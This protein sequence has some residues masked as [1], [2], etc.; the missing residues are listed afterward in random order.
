MKKSHRFNKFII[1]L[2]NFFWDLW[3][4]LSIIGIW[5]R[6][7]ENKLVSRTFKRF[8]ISYLP[9]DL[10][11]LKIAQFSDL[12][13]H[14]QVPQR[15]LEKIKRKIESFQPDIIVFTGDFLCFSLSRDLVRLEQFF[16]SLKAPYGCFAV[17]GNHDY[18]AFVSVNEQ[19]EYDVLPASTGSI[20]KVLKRLWTTKI[21][22]RRATDRARAVRPH[23][24]LE[25]TLGKTHFRLLKNESLLV[26]IKDTF[27]N[28]VGLEE[29]STGR[30]APA[31]A[32]QTVDPRFPG[33]VIAHNPDIVPHL[34]NFSWDVILCGHTHGGQVN[35]PWLWKKFTL[36]ENPYLKKGLICMQDKWIYVNRGIGSVMPFRWFSM[37]ELLLL[38]LET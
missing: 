13:L 14:P 36:M 2:P 4:C 12:H 28:I 27:I 1:N 29:Y 21:L 20:D 34:L 5:P 23:A 17:L 22:S 15:F 16:T 6:F 31:L 9:K 37:P 38:T 7:I 10:H 26:P 24:E 3:C 35:L 19:G 11:G 32:F 8:K 25:K 33:L 18:N 30:H